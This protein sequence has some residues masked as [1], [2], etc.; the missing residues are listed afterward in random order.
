MK[1][2]RFF[3]NIAVIT[4]FCC[5]LVSA[6]TAEA[7][8]V[9]E[10]MAA[11]LPEITA[12]KD[13]GLLGEDNKGYL[14]YIKDSKP[15]QDMVKA[16]NAGREKVYAAISKKEGVSVDLV[17]KRR[18]K[19]LFERGKKGHWFQQQDGKWVQK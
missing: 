14:A 4:L 17:G 1:E 19:M 9:K 8:S 6:L 15:E 18:A 12:L 16:E 2:M 10:R 13:K 3:R 5:F 7:A 11:R